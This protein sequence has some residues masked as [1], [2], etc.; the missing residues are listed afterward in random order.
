[1]R[2]F[3]AHLHAIAV[4][5]LVMPISV[6]ADW[7]QPRGNAFA[8]GQM[9]FG[10]DATEWTAFVRPADPG[11]LNLYGYCDPAIGADSIYVGLPGFGT[12]YAL[13]RT[14]GR[15]RWHQ[16]AWPVGGSILVNDHF[17]YGTSSKA[18]KGGNHGEFAIVAFD[19]RDGHLLWKNVGIPGDYA[20][21]LAIGT[22]LYVVF[23]S[24]SFT[25]QAFNLSTGAA[26]WQYRLEHRPSSA[27]L[28]V[29]DQVFVA[30]QQSM[31]SFNSRRGTVNWKSPLFK[32]E[33]TTH[34]AA[35]ETNVYAAHGQT[36]AIQGYNQ[37]TG[38][39]AWQYVGN[40]SA[41]AEN[42]F[43]Q[44]AIRNGTLYAGGQTEFLAINMTTK[45]I[46]WR[47]DGMYW[48]AP[49]IWE[50][51][52]YASDSHQL[53]ALNATTGKTVWR[54]EGNLQP[55]YGPVRGGA[56]VSDGIVY[57]KPI[58]SPKFMAINATTGRTGPLVEIQE[59][60]EKAGLPPGPWP[61][62]VLLLMAVLT[63]SRAS[64]R[65]RTPPRNPSPPSSLFSPLQRPKAAWPRPQA[66]ISV[67]RSARVAPQGELTHSQGR[68]AAGLLNGETMEIQ[69]QQNKENA[70][71]DRREIT[72]TLRHEGET[73]PSRVQVRQLLASQIGTKTE[74]VVI[75]LMESEYGRGTSRGVAR[76]YKT[77]DAARGTERVHM[78]KRNQLYIEKPKKEGAKEGDKPAEAKAAKPKKGA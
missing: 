1:M 58:Y 76:A 43:Q 75:D 28:V 6:G 42:G 67:P 77:A 13:N 32:P 48:Q 22:H 34:L 47:V 50:D 17:V 33:Q 63:R 37:K 74:N 10:S 26:E 56:L 51:R 44:P 78:L 2:F 46:H 21:T 35:D 49:A 11:R 53:L 20:S 62:I 73:T 71:L 45:Q 27:P 60:T 29:Q 68:R 3:L 41:S 31:Y 9:D 5:A 18:S 70:L 12:L 55:R 54:V 30:D 38:R 16:S 15:E 36:L 57:Y 69:I 8:T 19:A 72:F 4:V 14:T 39:V 24:L 64:L 66:L 7:L 23:T 52:V 40:A 25:V 61:G 59:Y 65:S